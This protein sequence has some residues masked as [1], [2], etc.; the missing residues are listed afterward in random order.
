MNDV[1]G[2]I[3]C[4]GEPFDPEKI[5]PLVGFS[6]LPPAFRFKVNMYQF[7]QARCHAVVSVRCLSEVFEAVG[8]GQC[9][10]LIHQAIHD[11][12]HMKQ[13]SL[14]F[15]DSGDLPTLLE[16]LSKHETVW[17]HFDR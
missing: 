7:G 2:M 5:I 13:V 12:L 8:V 15:C 11:Q 9:P 14:T 10:Y 16:V 6:A 3:T 17:M 4:G 1:N